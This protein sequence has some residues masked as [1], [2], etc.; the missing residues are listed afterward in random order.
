VKI[1]GTIKMIEIESES[2]IKKI[3][4]DFCKG[5][6][7]VDL[8]LFPYC[9][10]IEKELSINEKNTCYNFQFTVILLEKDRKLKFEISKTGSCGFDEV[11]SVEKIIKLYDD[12]IKF[13]RD[14]ATLQNKIEK[15]GIKLAE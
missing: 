2:P 8:H 4:D 10:K 14:M 1:K 15:E 5:K 11:C 3:I 9:I 7:V 6:Y 12:S 13:L